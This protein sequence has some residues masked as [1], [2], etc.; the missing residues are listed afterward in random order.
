MTSAKFTAT[1]SALGAQLASAAASGPPTLSV[2]FQRESENQC[3]GLSFPLAAGAVGIPVEIQTS[4]QIPASLHVEATEQ[5]S[6]SVI[7]LEVHT[8]KAVI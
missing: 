3:E 2:T 1:V 5:N 4:S 8:A 6:E 7:C